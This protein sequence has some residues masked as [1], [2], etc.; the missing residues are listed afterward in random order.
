MGEELADPI[1]ASQLEWSEWSPLVPRLGCLWG[2]FHAAGLG[3][4]FDDSP[5]KKHA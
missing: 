5:L 3:D 4:P 2:R 1:V